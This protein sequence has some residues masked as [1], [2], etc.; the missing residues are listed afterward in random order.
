MH[1]LGDS[2]PWRAVKVVK[3][4]NDCRAA[5]R[6]LGRLA[7]VPT[8]G[9]LHAGHVSLIDAAK[10]RVPH[11]AVSIFVNPTQFGPREDFSK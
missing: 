8:L 4:I 3:T 2:L 9:A 1:L 11:V 5:R 7:L 6:E 10:K